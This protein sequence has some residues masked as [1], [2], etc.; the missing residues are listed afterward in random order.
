[1]AA[2]VVDVAFVVPLSSPAGLFGPSCEACGRLAVE[3]VNANGGVLGR[4]L[5]LRVVDGG[6][7]PAAVASEVDSLV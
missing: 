2:E 5:R 6:R 1:M 7:S 3:E 4:E